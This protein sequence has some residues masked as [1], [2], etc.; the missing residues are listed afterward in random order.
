M[1]SNTCTI[2]LGYEAPVPTKSTIGFATSISE[3]PNR[4]EPVCFDGDAP[5]MTIAPT[6]AGKGISAVIPT[7][8][9]NKNPMVIVDPKGEIFNVTAR[10]RKAM[11]HKIVRLDPFNICEDIL[12][13]GAINPL[14]RLDPDDPGIVDDVRMLCSAL[15]PINDHKDP[16]WD[17]KSRDILMGFMLFVLSYAEPE[18][19]NL[20]S[21]RSLIMLDANKITK[22]LGAM[23]QSPLFNGRIREGANLYANMPEKTRESVWATL[24]GHIDFLGSESIAG[25]IGQSTVTEE[26]LINGE[27]VT[28][29]MVLPSAKLRSHGNLLRLWTSSILGTLAKRKKAPKNKTL[30]MVDEAA[31]LGR[32]DDLLTAIT[33]MRGYGVQPWTFW[34][35]LNQIESTYGKD[36]GT[37]L[38]NAGVL[39]I[40]GHTNGLSAMKVAALAGYDSVGELPP[41]NTDQQMIIR[42]GQGP[43]VC[44]KLNYLTDP[45]L[46]KLAS[47]NP[48]YATPE[49][50]GTTKKPNAAANLFR[51]CFSRPADAWNCWYGLAIEGAHQDQN[52]RWSYPNLQRSCWYLRKQ[53]W[54]FGLPSKEISSGKMGPSNAGG[55][56][57]RLNSSLKRLAAQTHLLNGNE[58]RAINI[59]R[60]QVN[61]R[62]QNVQNHSNSRW[63]KALFAGP[64]RKIKPAIGVKTE[65]LNAPNSVVTQEVP[66]SAKTSQSRHPK[67]QRGKKKKHNWSPG[68]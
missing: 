38:D 47:I 13:R 14:D 32:M 5:L 2:P 36:A 64:R 24:T 61:V 12:P 49:K 63:W 44:K 50:P 40:F 27:A 67:R 15:C 51:K 25:C 22:V 3:Q 31:Q 17:T 16:F 62:K 4:T 28:I 66:D 35:S 29:Y 10:A 11:G 56:I 34:Q 37:I 23:D 43:M 7:A 68:H 59:L 1:L 19:R 53:P 57:E 26:E 41:I 8:L 45:K 9:T 58:T 60:K 46:L 33:L 30:L 52:N 65:K 54:R 39:Q 20:A 48:M 55:D 18:S 21:V 6:G 42:P